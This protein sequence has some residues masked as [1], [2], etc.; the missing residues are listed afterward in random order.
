MSGGTFDPAILSALGMP[1]RHVTQDSRTVESGDVFLAFPGDRF[2]GRAYLDQAVAAGAAGVL[3]EADGFRWPGH[4]DVPQLGVTGLRE[5]AADIAAHVYGHPAETLWMAG[6]TGTNGKTSCAHW[7]AQALSFGGRRCALIGTLG[8]G[9][10]GKLRAATH[11]T[12]D[13]VTLQR[14]LRAFCDAGATAVAMEVS[15]HAI[16]QGRVQC[17][18]F[19]AALFTNLTRDHLDYHVDMASYGAAKEKLFSLPGLKSAVINLD[20]DFGR[21]LADRVDA[22]PVRVLR[23]GVGRGDIAAHRVDLSTRGLR[24]E[25]RT[26]WGPAELHS[27][28]LGG[29]NVSN[30][31]GSLGVLLSA[32]VALEPAV[33]ALSRVEPVRGRL[34][35]LRLPG[36]P[37]VVVDYAHTP[38]A[39]EKVLE[40]LL[41][42]V[43]HEPAARLL[44]VFGCGG[45]RDPGKRPLM[46][47]V[48]T[49]LAHRAI[50]TSD[51]P[52]SEDPRAIVDQIVAGARPNHE[53]EIDRAAAIGRALRLA[54]PSDVVLIAGKG[55]ETTQE[56]AGRLLPFDDLLV[57]RAALEAGVVPGAARV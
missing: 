54:T 41:E 28:M 29:F 26:P 24:L 39:L 44:C 37:L 22:S 12:P 23:Y 7:I 3:W 14:E 5:I 49:R 8:N 13:A 10:P 21:G 2:D 30:L 35:F 55:H 40:T 32:G 42:L 16:D 43:G 19:D 31:L 25:I 34:E 53:V 33:D 38:D 51:N 20:D 57:A 46:G 15:S 48:A 45:D 27:R 56:I 18:H 47:E 52:R 36:R 9:F 1:V 4:L 11:T 17:A 50:V 6:V